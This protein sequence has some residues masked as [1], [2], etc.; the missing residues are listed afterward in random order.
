M[1]IFKLLVELFVIYLLYKFIFDFVIPVYN[2]T[3]HVKQKMNTMQEQMRQQQQAYENNSYNNTSQQEHPKKP[4]PEGDY[5][6][7]EEVK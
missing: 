5:I 7:Y 2:T 1:N 3:K 4:V 6:D